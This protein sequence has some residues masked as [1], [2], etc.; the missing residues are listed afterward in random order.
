LMVMLI[1]HKHLRG[2]ITS[3]MWLLQELNSPALSSQRTVLDTLSCT[4]V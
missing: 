3:F 2:D 4:I 1:D